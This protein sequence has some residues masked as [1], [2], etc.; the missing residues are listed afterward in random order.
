MDPPSMEGLL[1]RL[2]SKKRPV[3]VQLPQAEFERLRKVWGLTAP[4][5]ELKLRS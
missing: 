3:L 1:R 2:D 5:P 4:I